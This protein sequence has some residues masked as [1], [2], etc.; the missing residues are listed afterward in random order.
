MS[1]EVTVQF[2]PDSRY[3]TKI[4]TPIG[5]TPA[6]WRSGVT[7][8][9]RSGIAVRQRACGVRH[10]VAN[11]SSAI[12]ASWLTSN[13][14]SSSAATL[15]SPRQLPVSVRPARPCAGGS[16]QCATLASENGN[17]SAHE[18]FAAPPEVIRLHR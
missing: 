9:N 18:A 11:R 3:S 2:V 12:T 6:A 14:V 8:R 1:F 7:S 5:S 17:S 4:S 15:S 16:I 13:M 10:C